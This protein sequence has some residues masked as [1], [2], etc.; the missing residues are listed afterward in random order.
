MSELMPMTFPPRYPL[1]SPKAKQYCRNEIS[2]PDPDPE[3]GITDFQLTRSFFANSFPPKPVS[4]HLLPAADM[5]IY[6]WEGRKPQ[7]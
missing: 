2:H 4:V 1:L 6:N 7:V 5:Y 3:Q